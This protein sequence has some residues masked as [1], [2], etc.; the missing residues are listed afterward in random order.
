MFYK[1]TQIF[2]NTFQRPYNNNLTQ[3]RCHQQSPQQPIVEELA[4]QY[5]IVDVNPASPIDTEKM[6]VMLAVQPSSLGPEE[7]NNFI[8]AV[9]AGVPTAIFEDPIVAL[10]AVPGTGDPKQPGNQMMMMGQAV[11]VKSCSNDHN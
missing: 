10:S 3:Q 1:T 5:E 4:K 11:C 2:T 7:I 9:K 8:N 6:D